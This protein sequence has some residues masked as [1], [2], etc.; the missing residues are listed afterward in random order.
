MLGSAGEQTI[1]KEL[2]R[3]VCNYT[4]ILEAAGVN[5][6][7]AKCEVPVHAVMSLDHSG[8]TYS[9]KHCSMRFLF[10]GYFVQ[11]NV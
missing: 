6:F 5:E 7:R 1:L 10:K 2:G 3:S 9:V 11:I 4:A 8:H